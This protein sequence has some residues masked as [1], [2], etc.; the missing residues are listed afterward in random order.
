MTGS[1]SFCLARSPFSRK[2]HL[3][4]VRTP[5]MKRYLQVLRKPQFGYGIRALHP[6][7][8]MFQ[9][10]VLDAPDSLEVVSLEEA[11]VDKKD[12]VVVR[13]SIYRGERFA[14]CASVVT[15]RFFV[16]WGVAT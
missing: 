3:Q 7:C 13:G 14:S 1:G 4:N 8:V 16:S 15:I 12:R 9:A 5:E 10:M 11:K 2:P 6:D